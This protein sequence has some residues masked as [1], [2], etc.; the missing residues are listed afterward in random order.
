V[1]IV[2]AIVLLAIYV[3]VG[4]MLSSLS[5]AYQ[6][7]ILQELNHRV[8]F[9]I[10][11]QRVSAEWHSF[12]PVLVF[13]GLRLTLPGERERSL[14][15]SEGR[16]ALD[17]AAS[18]R[19]RSLQMSLLRLNGLDLAGDLGADG[20]LR[21]RGFDGSDTPLGDWLQEFLLNVE[22]AALGDAHLTLALADGEQ[23]E[24]DLDLA[25][26][27]EG[28]R[29]RLEAKLASSHGLE[30]SALAQGVGNPFQPGSFSGQLYLDVDAADVGAVTDLAGAA[31]G[32]VRVD[33]SL[34]LEMWTSWDQGEAETVLRVGMDNALLRSVDG[35]WQLPADRF[36]FNAGLERRNDGWF[37]AV[38]PLELARGEL[39]FE[40]PR[41]QLH[42]HGETLDLRAQGLP[43]ES[44]SGLVAGSE[45]LPPGGADLINA[46]RPR[47]TL[48]SLQLDVDDIGTPL[49]QWQLLANFDGL[50]V[51]PWHGAPGVTGASGHVR[52]TP[53]SGSVVLDT[54]QFSMAF[55][56]VYE[57][58]LEYDDFHGTIDIHWDDEAVVLSSGLVE[59]HGEEGPV[60]VLFGLSVPLVASQVGLEMDLM[61]GLENSRASHRGKYIPYILSQKLRP[62][63]A[64]SIGDGLIEQGGFIWRGSLDPDSTA[65]HTV[66][67]F[68]NV[69]DAALGFDPDWPPLA[70][71]DGTVLINDSNVSVWADKAQLLD[72]GVHDLSV[73]AWLDAA[74]ELW[75]AIDGEV[76]GPAADGL[77]VVNGSPLAQA[78]GDVF[79]D[80]QLEGDLVTQIALLLDLGDDPAPP[81][82]HVSSRFSAVN[83]DIRPGELPL[84]GISGELDYDT[85]T[86]FSSRDLVGQLWGR[87]LQASV[88]QLPVSA[89]PGAGSGHSAVS[90]TIAT[91]VDMKDVRNWLGL[92][93][94]AFAKGQAAAS[95]ELV[96][97]TGK[98]AQLSIDSSLDGISLDLPVPWGKP[99][100]RERGL[101]LT[102]APG[103]D[104][105]LLGIAMAD[106]LEAEL[107]L[108]GGEPRSAAVALGGVP[109]QRQAGQV[110]VGGHA[111]FA[112]ATQWQDFLETYFGAAAGAKQVGEGGSDLAFII[113][114]LQVDQLV[115]GGRDLGGVLLG[116]ADDGGHWRVTASNEWL[117]GELLY[118]AGARSS[119]DLHFLDLAGLD[120]L[121]LSAGDEA[122]IVRVP[123]LAVSIGELRRGE[124]LLG[125]LAFDL[126]SDGPD[127]RAT[128]ISGELFSMQLHTAQP[129]ELVW[130][131][132]ADSHTSLAATLHF[133]DLGDTLQ[134]LGYEQAIVTREGS[135]DLALEW[136]GGPQD[137]S[138][139]AGKGSLGVDI[140][141]G[142]FP[143]V[144]AGASGTLRVVSILNLAEIVR[145][146]SLSQMFESGIPFDKVEGEVSLE[147]GTIAVANM[148][149]QGSASSFQFSGISD[150]AS[151]TLDGE[152]VVTLPVANNLPWVAALTAGLPVAAGVFLLSKV[153][154]SQFNRL[155]SAVYT[156]TGTWD[157]PVVRFDR[158]FDDT[159]TPGAIP[160][161]VAPPLAPQ[162]A[163][164][165]SP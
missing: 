36:A 85:S 1:A 60:R 87:P 112:D 102:L 23:R 34:G 52:L 106:E 49:A 45:A 18:F 31:L 158:V 41:L 108:V 104:S 3:S 117:R 8:P 30:V 68:F 157:D 19:T 109:V 124:T 149:V 35:S 14:E 96:A 161:A 46:L 64:A 128:D 94:L 7:E 92:E 165:G 115:A 28:S 164:S 56:T 139:Q 110:R 48:S 138:L 136:P 29:R 32:K 63:L 151:R 15:I 140:G 26:S 25:L 133:G 101:H 155:T 114:Q 37:L 44:L 59:A 42:V 11:A 141:E 130:H 129:G 2:I 21:I 153:F 66:Q 127:I 154:E 62:W 83:L 98:P 121:D 84:R 74:D 22:R 71:I 58:A 144:S 27:R 53:G 118:I 111:A 57:Q 5:G 82:V 9:I 43:L 147:D 78:A 160:P 156:A 137:F 39:R 12:T 77:A 20:S 97:G 38:A 150:V 93:Q 95:L 162:P 123:E 152:L 132:G 88:A 51:D 99:A 143:D 116:A 24:F 79:R 75:L 125:S 91:T 148:D 40:L 163:Q 89:E 81:D 47:G 135:F 72:S 146:L 105:L 69:R 6:R 13:D 159:A 70:H 4:R 145:R 65:L 86:G 119:L 10:D 67:L 16:I 80:W 55:P 90:V 131:Q 100:D 54:R 17:V 122:E 107:E 113:D 33:G 126:R 134:G 120:N 61:V 73:E 50:A 142:H 76:A 103:G